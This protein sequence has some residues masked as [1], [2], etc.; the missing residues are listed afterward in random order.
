MLTFLAI[1]AVIVLLVLA[2]G[3]YV[4]WFSQCSLIEWIFLNG[5]FT[6]MI[7]GLFAIL[8]ALLGSDNS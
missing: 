1:V 2:I 6:D 3:L 8:L 5:F 7:G 4:W